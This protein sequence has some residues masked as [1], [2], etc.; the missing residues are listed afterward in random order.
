MSGPR[1]TPN[2]RGL[3]QLVSSYRM[4]QAMTLAALRVR[5]QALAA[6]P[7]RSGAYKESFDVEP[8]RAF[9]PTYRNPQVRSVAYVTSSAPHAVFLEAYAYQ[10]KRRN[11][12]GSL[13]PKRSKK[14]R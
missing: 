2:D 5:D 13:T 14:K 4:Q 8:A 3:G 10:H 12:L 9:I 6:A 11:T 1:F 7:E